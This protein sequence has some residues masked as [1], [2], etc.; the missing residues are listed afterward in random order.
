[1]MKFGKPVVVLAALVVCSWSL[2]TQ[3]GIVTVDF[4]MDDSGNSLVNGQVIS[5]APDRQDALGNPDTFFEFGT[6]MNVSTTQGPGGHQGAVIFDS[7]P[8]GPNDGGGDED[9]L[10]DL[11][12]VITLQNNSSPDV[13][14]TGAGAN[15][16]V[17]DTPN[18]VNQFDVGSI[19]FDFTQSV[20]PL[21]VD[22]VDMNGGA[23]MEV[24]MTDADGLTRTYTIPS[25]WTN[26]VENSPNGFDTLSLTTTSP[27]DGEGPGGDA[28]AVEDLG[29]EETDVVQMEFVFRGNRSS[30]GAF[31][32]LV[33]DGVDDFEIPEPSCLVLTMLVGG[34]LVLRREAR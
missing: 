10:V 25:Q 27:Q 12:N 28:T 19:V 14:D 7:D 11:G 5:T 15:G 32:N 33:L 21:Q 23:Q 6:L 22:I 3:A 29:F 2:P 13:T 30:S 4:E 20:A 17:F 24:V 31:D 8:N 9:L 34:L 18:D 16:L 26:D 1:M